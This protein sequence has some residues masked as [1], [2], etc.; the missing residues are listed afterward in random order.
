MMRT[1]RR[2][3]GLRCAVNL[4]V[5]LAF[6]WSLSGVGFAVP[7][8]TPETTDPPVSAEAPPPA[9]PAPVDEGA[10]PPAPDEAVDEAPP[11]AEPAPVEAEEPRAVEAVA[12]V[13]PATPEPPQP[14]PDAGGYT[15]VEGNPVLCAF[16]VRIDGEDLPSSGTE[17]FHRT[18]GDFEMVITITVHDNEYGPTFDFSTSW[19]VDRVVA[20]GGREGANI[21]EYDPAVTA[22]SALHSPINPSGK[23]AGLSHIDFCFAPAGQIELLKF[24]DLDHDGVYDDEPGLAGWE[25]VLYHGDQIVDSVITDADGH[26]TF[27]GL[28]PGEYEIRE[29]A[30]MGWVCTTTHPLVVTVD[31]DGEE[32][33]RFGNAET[34][35][36]MVHKFNDLN[37]DGD[38]DEGEPDL[39][40]FTMELR[41]AA[42]ALVDTDVTDA[43][44]HAMFHD[45]FLGTYYVTE[46]AKPGWT[47]T[48]P[49]PVMAEVLGDRN[50]MVHIGNVELS[51]IHVLKFHDIDRDGI[52]DTGEPPVPG[53]TIGLTTQP[54]IAEESPAA[55]IAEVTDENGMVHF[56]NLGAGEYDVS[57]VVPEGWYPTTPTSFH[58]NLAQGEDASIEFGNTYDVTKRF[59]LTY[60]S[61]PADTS[62]WVR[63]YVDDGDPQMLRLDPYE[64]DIF[65]G[66]VELPYG[67]VIAGAWLASVGSEVVGLGAFGDELLTEDVT[68]EFEYTA[69]MSGH[70]Y[71]DDNADGT[72]DEGEPGLSGWTILL[73]RMTEAGELP[74]FTPA[75]AGWEL[76]ATTVTGAG[77]V[78]SFE[79]LPPGLY[80]VEES[81]EP[82]WTQ[83]D[84]PANP[85]EVGDGTA[86]VDLDFGNNEPIL[87]FTD[88]SL[89]KVADR[90]TARPGDTVKYTLTYGNTGGG[91]I[92]EITIVDDFDERYLTPVDVAG[93]TV[94]GGKITWLDSTPLP[95]GTERSITYTLKIDSTMP[96]GVT[97]LRNVAIIDPGGYQD[98]WTVRVSTG[99]PF[100]PF[101]GSELGV[102]LLAALAA[103]GA[104][105]MLRLASRPQSF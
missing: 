72:W 97:S 44:G 9:A 17:V 28:A 88:T 30:K 81:L 84:S 39:E 86:L 5:A 95:S 57:E 32:S 3:R 94:S 36:L 53:V 42:G 45:L 4:T 74:N 41:D 71:S 52:H 96:D 68:N 48:T 85:F 21:Y 7:P 47:N 50:T 61:L 59:E 90:T 38:H 8:D 56:G 100:L 65:A 18:V 76:F 80:K 46:L 43:D 1:L 55:A 79:G 87:P 15:T 10:T 75:V 37:E 26:A 25:F 63:Y 6:I 33:V 105:L 13:T 24:N 27:A 11:P 103:A 31:P 104:G 78:Y 20:K 83:T 91:T 70:K 73:F 22:G 67:S 98:E 40:G 54:P 62:L 58:V 89:T 69:S 92:D 23:W 99:E 19:P 60:P 93:G 14:P 82:G 102:L 34:S 29:Q 64:G 49:L 35:A 66:E 101:T 51:G 12:T 2:H 16:G 77:G